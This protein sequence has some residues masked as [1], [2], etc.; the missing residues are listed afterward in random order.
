MALGGVSAHGA[1]ISEG[2]GCHVWLT[3]S[4]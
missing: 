3:A 4:L 1:G 2:G